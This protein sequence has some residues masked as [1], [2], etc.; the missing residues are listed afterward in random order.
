MSNKLYISNL[1]FSVTDTQLNDLFANVGTVV[2]AR[3][4]M[5][6]D[7]G[8]SKGFGFVEMSTP[9]EAKQAIKEVNGLEINGRA[10]TVAEARPQAPR[11]NTRGG[12]NGGFGGARY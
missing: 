2:S 4:I 1:P 5:N 6:R 12:G 11:E 7:T 10:L 8:R 9:E 3:V